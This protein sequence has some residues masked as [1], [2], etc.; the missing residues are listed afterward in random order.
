MSGVVV[1]V[2]REAVFVVVEIVEV[3]AGEVMIVG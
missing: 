3:M 2:D 1:L